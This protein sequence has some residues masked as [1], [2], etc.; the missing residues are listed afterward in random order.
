MVLL[1]LRQVVV[2]VVDACG[3]QR[4]L[5][6]G[7]PRVGVVELV[8]GDDCG[9]RRVELVG[10]ACSL[11]VG[12]CLPCPVTRSAWECRGRTLRRLRHCRPYAWYRAS[13]KATSA[14]AKRRTPV[15]VLTPVG[16]RSSGSG[17][18]DGAPGWCAAPSA[19]SAVAPTH[20]GRGRPTR[21]GRAWRPRPDRRRPWPPS[22][23]G[24]G[25]R[26]AARR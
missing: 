9:L 4:Y 3:E 18:G 16:R 10:H 5:H 17:P 26:P 19:G 8:V 21:P 15:L 20:G 13:D 23:L 25:A 14:E 1:V 12:D 2:E 7:R 24:R 22:G 6:L 11:S